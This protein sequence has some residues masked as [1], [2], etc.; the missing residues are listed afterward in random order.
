M[1]KKPWPKLSETL[2]IAEP[3]R[4]GQCGSMDRLTWWQEC[5]ERDRRTIAFVC[6]CGPCADKIIE[7]HPRLYVQQLADEVMPGAMPICADCPHR[8][9]RFCQCPAAK[10]NGGA[11]IVFQP[12]PSSLHLNCGRKSL[13][14]WHW[15]FPEPAT[16]C[17]GKEGQ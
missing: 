15:I 16:A 6:L 14:G 5:D 7:P 10:F 9:G 11:G 13:S 8:E 17:S 4:C 1:S 2:P 12:R 3:G